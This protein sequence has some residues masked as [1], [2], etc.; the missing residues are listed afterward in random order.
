MSTVDPTTQQFRLSQLIYDTRYR[1]L[2]IQV[3]AI[4]LLVS[5]GWWL[6]ANVVSN[7]QALGK[8]FDFGF[9]G[10]TA[11]YDINQRLVPY[12]S[13][14]VH[15]KAALV[16][17][18][19]TILV[20]ILGCA[21]ATVVGV[22]AGV[23]RLSKNWIVNK[24][25]SVYVEGFRNVPLLL[26]ILL[27]FAVV[28]ESSPAARAFR[29]DPPDA[30]MSFFNLV[31][32]TNNGV[33]IPRLGWSGLAWLFIVVIIGA[34][35]ANRIFRT[36]A[37]KRQERTGQIILG[38][39]IS[40]GIFVVPLLITF[41]ATSLVSRSNEQVLVGLGASGPM[42]VSA[43]AEEQGRFTLCYVPDT[44][45][46]VSLFRKVDE[47]GI[48]YRANEYLS[49]SR[50]IE[51]F[52]NERCSLI[53][54][55][56]GRAEA[57]TADLDDTSLTYA[58]L[59]ETVTEGWAIMP[60][61]PE[62]TE[63]GIPRFEGGTTLRNALIALWLALALYTGA[64]IAEIVRGGILAVSKGQTE[65]AFALGLRPN[66]TMNLVILPQALRV[67]IPPL[68]S[69]Y[70]NL[71]KNSSLAIAVGYM[72]VRSTLGGITINQT[73]RELEGMLL[74]GAFYLLLSLVISSLMNIYNERVKLKER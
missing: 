58:V 68:I 34:I 59:D 12:D 21:L 39:P 27:I 38:W 5:A 20:A 40:L 55:P 56:N 73:G 2:T 50:A 35:I 44:A 17:I 33:Y 18:L 4:V 62:I 47:A 60:R 45:R 3:I 11:G 37:R 9:L 71:T 28:N 53:A 36:W 10:Q 22:I 61:V 1:S 57:L 72:D 8:D 46:S 30:T 15:A 32:F 26:W 29:G 69:Q 51:D 42:S 43:F 24:L 49:T 25:M 23:L 14:S 54:L 64:F 66:W 65:A 52:K 7:L 13:T 41:F 16:G 6:V 48:A 31:A 63:S 19:N 70:L 67:I 74:L